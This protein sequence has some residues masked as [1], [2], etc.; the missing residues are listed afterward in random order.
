MADSMLA[1]ALDHEALYSLIGDIKPVSQT[2]YVFSYGLEK[3][4]TDQDGQAT[5]VMPEQDSVRQVLQVL[6]RWNSITT[7]LSFGPYRFVIIPFR[8]TWNGGRNFQI[9]VCRTDLIDR[10]LVKRAA[11]FA[12]WGFVPGTDPAVLLTAVEFGEPLDRYRAYGY[13][14]GY[15]KH[16]VDFF[17][18]AA[19]EEK[20]TGEFV[21]RDFFQIPVHAKSSGYFTYAVP[22]GYQPVDRDSALYYRSAAVLD[23]YRSM[24]PRFLDKGGRL[25]A[26]RL[27]RN[28]W[29]RVE[30][31]AMDYPAP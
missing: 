18:E 8:R 11:F 12:Q 14:F 2:G 13:L 5:V 16:A 7:A 10:L 28:Y 31:S 3:D 24:R 25:N 21:E 27:L 22:E 1:F 19:R 9:A 6:E 15:P 30:H 4:S 26:V 17:V 20:R 29:K 23:R